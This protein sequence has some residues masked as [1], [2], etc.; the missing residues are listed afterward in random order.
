MY[1]DKYIRLFGDSWT[2]IKHTTPEPQADLEKSGKGS[3]YAVKC[4]QHQS[5]NLFEN[6]IICSVLYIN[7]SLDERCHVG[8]YHHHAR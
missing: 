6:Y 3:M 1:T 8:L 2:Y 4:R 7:P 5:R